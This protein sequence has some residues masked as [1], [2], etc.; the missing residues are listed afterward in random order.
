MS[1]EQRERAEALFSEARGLPRAERGAFLE[2]SCPDDG[3]VRAE[4]EAMLAADGGD[5]PTPVAGRAAHRRREGHAAPSVEGFEVHGLLGVGGMGVVWEAEQLSPRRRVALKVV[6]GGSLVDELHVR[7]FQREADTLARLKH[8]D[9]A[10]IYETGQTATGESY[11]AMEYVAGTTLDLFLQ[12]RMPA[13]SIGP[14]EVR[15]R[16]EL[17]LRIADAVH[18]AH[19]RGVIHR[20]LKPANILVS[21]TRTG[22]GAALHAGLELKV[23]DF[24]IARITDTDREASL[25]TEVGLIKGTLAYMSPEQARGERDAIDVRTDVYSLGVILYEMLSGA[26]PKQVDSESLVT[27][28]REVTEGDA[29]PLAATY[30][31]KGRLDAD[32]VTI[33][34]K[35]LD[36]SPEGRYAGVDAFAED[37]RLWLQGLPIHARRPTTM[38]LLRKM[39]ARNKLA[40]AFGAI[41][42]AL[43]LGFGVTMSVL[44]SEA[45]AAREEAQET[46]V[47]LARTTQ[48]LE[49]TAEFQAR[50]LAELDAEV[51]GRNLF[52]NLRESLREAYEAT[53]GSESRLA[54]TLDGLQAL[55]PTDLALGV[56]DDDILTRAEKAAAA[57]FA[58]RPAVRGRLER[59]LGRTAGKL[60]LYERGERLLR[61]AVATLGSIGEPTAPARTDL[62]EMLVFAG[63]WDQA[64]AELDQALAE[65]AE[66]RED[67]PESVRTRS[68]EVLLLREQQQFDELEPRCAA[69]VALCTRIHGPESLETLNARENRA[70]VL[71]GLGRHDEAEAEYDEILGIARRVLGPGDVTTANLLHNAGLNYAKMGRHDEALAVYTEALED[72]RRIQGDEHSETLVSIVNLSRLYARLERYEEA[73]RWALEALDLAKR[74]AR[75]R[76][77]DMAMALSVVGTAWAGEERFAEAEEP[78]AQ[79]Y[80]L[81]AELL[82]PRSGNAR[83][84]AEKIVAGLEQRGSEKDLALWRARAKP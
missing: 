51:L 5:V 54:V 68:V 38:Y 74:I 67:D 35:A 57:E 71:S 73:E 25:V 17:F 43:T 30:R 41:V 65:Q 83:A 60:G 59:S 20:D 66:A 63:S 33:C 42:A 28:L 26:L 27:N 47:R 79:A 12:E 15:Y 84:M 36:L 53:P 76:S 70:F 9:I 44:R 61:A 2:A 34:H 18:Y 16:L 69:L 52:R 49:D 46:V 37:V 72:G 56:L 48:D 75:P 80:D 4:V 10:A 45:E 31:G 64:R 82:G 32:V 14:E 24:G 78:L 7:M 29:R 40:S 19:Q 58:E 11:F 6:R 1:P 23:L 22:S 21:E 62:A 8:R 13:R 55:N 3:L 39:V 50:M 81:F 77:I